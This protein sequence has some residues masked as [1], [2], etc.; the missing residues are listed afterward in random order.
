[1]VSTQMPSLAIWDPLLGSPLGGGEDCVGNNLVAGWGDGWK[2]GCGISA[3]ARSPALDSVRDSSA[4][5][6]ENRWYLSFKSKPSLLCVPS[7]PAT[8]RGLVPG[9]PRITAPTDAQV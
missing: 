2:E 6:K 1:M 7:S 3:V 5:E 4:D 9:L 8:C